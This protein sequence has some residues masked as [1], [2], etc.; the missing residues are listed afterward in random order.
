VSSLAALC[1]CPVLILAGGLGTR[2]RPVVTDRPKALAPIGDQP[3]LEIQISLLREQGARRFVLC[4]GHR[5]AQVREAMGDG[6]RLGV[7]IEYSIEGETLL[8]TGGALRLA[9]H[10]VQ[11][12]ALV[13][14]GDTY[15]AADY[16]ELLSHHVAER[17]G[18]GVVASLTLARLEDARRFGTVLLESSGRY[19]AGFHEKEHGPVG[20]G[21]LNAGAYVIERDLVERIPA[22][23]PCSLE[24]DVFPGA[25]RAGQRLAAFPSSQPFFDI[26]TPDDFE[27]FLGL[28]AEWR[29]RRAEADSS[30]RA[31]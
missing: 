20:A 26:G 22:G 19:L 23:V 31:G 4:V 14:N 3:F 25:L 15:L 16:A 1:E 28:H 27:G 8:G 29:R 6:S 11:P 12:R 10:F 2:L 5:A 17:A 24:R 7:R 13:L 9:Q 21:W 30:R 18:A